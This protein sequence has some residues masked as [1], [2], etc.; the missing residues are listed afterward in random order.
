MPVTGNLIGKKRKAGNIQY[1]L[2]FGEE[3]VFHENDY[4]RPPTITSLSE[5]PFKDEID[6]LRQFYPN[7]EWAG[8]YLVEGSETAPTRIWHGRRNSINAMFVCVFE[9]LEGL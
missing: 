2:V 3:I 5:H 9:D 1:G 6:W 7:A 8:Y 4:H